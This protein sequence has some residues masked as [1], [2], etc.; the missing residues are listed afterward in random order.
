MTFQKFISCFVTKVRWKHVFGSRRLV[1]ELGGVGL[2]PTE[3]HE[4]ADTCLW[5]VMCVWWRSDTKTRKHLCGTEAIM[6][7]SCFQRSAWSFFSHHHLRTASHPVRSFSSKFLQP[8][9]FPP[10]RV[11]Y[12]PS[13]ESNYG[14]HTC[15]IS[16]LVFCN[17]QWLYLPMKRQL[18]D[19]SGIISPLSANAGQTL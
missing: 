3:F 2:I 9:D 5:Q 10:L 13:P 18:R 17:S 4:D 16:F 11:N 6:Q 8:P 14:L 7:S 1:K 15:R 12:F 19:G